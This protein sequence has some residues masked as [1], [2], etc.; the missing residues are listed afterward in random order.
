MGVP[1]IRWRGMVSLLAAMLLSGCVS[2]AQER[3]EFSYLNPRKPVYGCAAATW[4]VTAVEAHLQGVAPREQGGVRTVPR[5]PQNGL[6]Y[7][8]ANR[9]DLDADGWPWRISLEYRTPRGY[10]VQ[11][12]GVRDHTL[13]HG[14]LCREDERAHGACPNRVAYRM[15]GYASQ[16]SSGYSVGWYLLERY[17][18]DA[19]PDSVRIDEGE[20]GLTYQNEAFDTVLDWVRSSSCDSD[21]DHAQHV[22]IRRIE[23]RF[24]PD[25]RPGAHEGR[26]EGLPEPLFA[27]SWPGRRAPRLFHMTPEGVPNWPLGT[28]WQLL[29]DRPHHPMLVLDNVDTNGATT[30]AGFLRERPNA[31]APW[32]AC[33]PEIPE[34]IY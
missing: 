30:G 6:T 21:T 29:H 12:D 9:R 2:T 33:I 22:S 18:D 25:L 17:Q 23:I 26:P 34:F 27:E 10:V 4:C 31:S 1:T 7:V 13:D 20:G 14:T 19:Y 24:V 16:S 8:R 32:D 15:T 28:L 3:E 11:M 5:R